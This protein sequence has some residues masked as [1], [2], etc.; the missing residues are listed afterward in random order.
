MKKYW[1]WIAVAC[2]SA[3]AVPAFAADNCSVEIES[4]DAMQF[5]QKAMTVPASCKQFTVKLKHVGKM[6]KTA[7]GHNWVLAK[8]ADMQGVSTDGIAA[9]ADKDYLK[10]SDARVIAHT[11]LIGGGESDSVTFAVNKLKAGDDYSF[12]CSFPGHSGL[13]KGALTLAK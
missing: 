5:N 8:T 12:F 4:N 1:K 7:M 2:V 6:P 13:M 9:G 3:A 11:R 10:P